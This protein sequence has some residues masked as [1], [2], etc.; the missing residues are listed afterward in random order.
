MADSKARIEEAREQYKVWSEAWEK[1]R[2][3]EREDLRY[4]VSELQWDD[5]AK[6][7]R[8]GTK[9]TTGRPMLSISKLDQP[10]MLILNQMRSSD[11][12]VQAH[13]ISE[14]A[15][16]E[17]ADAIQG[18]YRHIERKSRA[19]LARYS[20]FDRAVTA[21]MGAYRVLTEYDDEGGDPSDQRIVIKRILHQ[22]G[23][24]FD[25]AA[26]EPDFRDGRAV[27]VVQWISKDEFARLYP[28]SKAAG[29]SKLDWESLGNEAP[30]WVRDDDV[31]VAERWY[32]E[33]TEEE[34]KAGDGTTR[35]REGV[36]VY[37]C[38]MSGWEELGE[39]KLWPGKYIPIIP[40]IGRELQPFDEERRFVGMIRPARDGQK[41][42]NFAASTLVERMMLEPKAPFVV[43]VRSIEGYESWWKQAN[44]RNLSY[45]P[46][47]GVVDGQVIP[48][49]QR[50]QIDSSGM[51]LAMMALQ[52][53]DQ[54]I[55]AST[56]VFD[57]SL[58]RN[59]QKERSGKAIMASQQQA[60]S[61]TSHF[62]QNFAD[63]SM[64]YE[65]DVILDLLPHI[66]D[67]QG[68]VTQIVRGDDGKSEPAMLGMPYTVDPKTKRPV[69][70]QPG[71]PGVKTID[72][73]KGRY[74]V[75]VSVGKNFQTRLEHGAEF[76]TDLVSKMPALIPM[77]GDLVFQFRD[78][79]GA[80]EIA[81]RLA[82][83]REK[84]FPGLGEGEEGGQ[85]SPEQL[86]GQIEQMGQAMKGMQGQLQAAMHA[87]ETEQ[88][89]QE[90][91]RLKAQLE[92]QTRMHTAEL[93]SQTKREIAAA[94]N[95]TKLEI[96]NLGARVDEM[97]TLLKVQGKAYEIEAQAAH[98][99]AQQERAL[100]GDVV[101]GE[102][103]RPAPEKPESKG[104]AE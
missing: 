22:D 83:I 25:P 51:S 65:A 21:G 94:D 7:E 57:P 44:S 103:A 33:R 39:P 53:A 48:P 100:V 62:L 38:K 90:T 69:P 61:A 31:L 97:L 45:L 88:A 47:N 74:A 17:T 52:E 81:K 72:L 82:K 99:D 14:D 75:S 60:D 79:P 56:S 66:Y 55:Q 54:F 19:E 36:K 42:Y 23:V 43:D 32:K 87:M 12:G 76:M 68:R 78:D 58:G 15:G 20:G 91:A 77:I 92:A 93:E 34:F 11:L 85:P 6:A 10:R 73:A 95:A 37:C 18:L 9:E 24:L 80:R 29:V 59:S 67:R 84:Q 1:Q 5:K 46:Y 101:K 28:K 40:V 49:P 86:K 96:A 13:P 104:E 26:V 63:I 98:D 41:L 50:A 89:K 27:F 30:E 35:K 64:V 102:L 4:Q 2:D 16:Q 70:A 3:R 71:Q 8:Q